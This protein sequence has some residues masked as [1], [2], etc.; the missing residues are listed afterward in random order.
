M[1]LKNRRLIITLV[2]IVVILLVYMG[3]KKFGY[4]AELDEVKEITLTHMQ[5][6]YPDSICQVS[7]MSSNSRS[8]DFWLIIKA[9][10]GNDELIFFV[11]TNLSDRSVDEDYDMQLI[12]NEYKKSIDDIL[13]RIDIKTHTHVLAHLLRDEILIRVTVA[14]DEDSTKENFVDHAIQ[15]KLAIE[16]KNKN[17]ID[18]YVF[19]NTTNF[20]GLKLNKENMNLTKEEILKNNLVTNGY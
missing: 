3:E 17:L 4:L 11:Q 19:Q 16:E 6:K 1:K 20:Y 14:L 18:M 2:I 12:A 7:E 9:N 8:G 15:I 13:S 5:T 10:D